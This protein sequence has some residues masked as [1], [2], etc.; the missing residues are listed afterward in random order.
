MAMFTA[1]L[2]A[3]AV[4]SAHVPSKAVAAAEASV[5]IVKPARVSLSDKPQPEGHKQH[6]TTVTVEDG[7]QRSALLVEFQ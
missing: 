3:A 7:S 1:F 2:L 6:Q 4:P 5:R